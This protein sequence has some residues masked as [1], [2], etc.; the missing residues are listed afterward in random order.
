MCGRIHQQIFPTI[1]KENRITVK[2]LIHNVLMTVYR[3][4]SINREHILPKNQLADIP[5]DTE[6]EQIYSKIVNPQHFYDTV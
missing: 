1:Q 4:P 3:Q 6:R 2:F 5:K